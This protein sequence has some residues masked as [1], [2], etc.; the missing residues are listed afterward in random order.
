MRVRLIALTVLALLTSWLII[1]SIP[2][3]AE[4]ITLTDGKKIRGEITEVTRDSITVETKDGPVVIPQD[5][6]KSVSEEEVSR[7]PKPEIE[8]PKVTTPQKKEETKEHPL[9]NAYQGRLNQTEAENTADAW[10]KLGKWCRINKMEGLAKEA[11]EKAIELEPYHKGARQALGHSR[12]GKKWMSDEEA[13]NSGY[14]RDENGK[15][16]KKDEYIEKEKRRLEEERREAEKLRREKQE[17]E[18]GV[19]WEQRH[20]LKS[21]HYELHTN[22]SKANA[23]MYLRVMEALYKKYSK[24][25][26]ALEPKHK[27]CVVHIRRSQQEFMQAYR[28]SRGVGGFYRPGQGLLVAFHGRFGLTGSTMTVLAHEGCHQFQDLFCGGRMMSLP[29]WV[30]EGMAVIFESAEIDSRKGKV[31]LG[32]L[33]TD[34]VRNLQGMM[35]Q[36][37]HV[38]IPRMLSTPQRGFGGAH[39]C[40]GGAFTWWLLKDSKKKK[41]KTLY[42]QY[43]VK[44]IRGKRRAS[45]DGSDFGKMAQEITGKTIQELEQEWQKYV[46]KIEIPKFGV[47]AGMRFISK[48]YRFEVAKPNKN[49]KEIKEE[50]DLPKGYAMLW[51][52]KKLKARF[53]VR[54]ARNQNASLDIELQRFEQNAANGKGVSGFKML[55]KKR[56]YV[57]AYE[58]AE[59]LYECTNSNSTLSQNLL[60]VRRMVIVTRRTVYYLV[61]E[62]EAD[63]WN[64]ARKDFKKI[65]DSFKLDL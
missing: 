43:L 53:S 24:V 3:Y 48:S 55:H 54:Y 26:A 61:A 52:N 37:R 28:M 44:I 45:R 18:Q 20:I 36:N 46:M 14:T 6:I 56:T 22:V 49:W 29:I 41:Y 10:C 15:F 8:K 33:N 21:K 4:V 32:G 62:C 38:T 47:Y 5:Q 23:D 60:K 1:P 51:N 12:I 57:G 30:I 59:F 25:F 34:R 40:T 58:A 63:R 17:A 16:V 2:G 27:T 9:W 64:K 31:D 50:T 7:E 65:F 19:P 39:Y 13:A 42:E 35:K 11:F